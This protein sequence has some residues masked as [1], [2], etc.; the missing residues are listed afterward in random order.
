MKVYKVDDGIF[1]SRRDDEG[2][3]FL[4]LVDEQMNFATP[5]TV[6]FSLLLAACQFG[7]MINCALV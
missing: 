4:L 7:K 3:C 2:K 6:I 5:T 1:T